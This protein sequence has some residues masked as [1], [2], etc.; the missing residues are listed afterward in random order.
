MNANEGKKVHGYFLEAY[1]S[2]TS[3]VFFLDYV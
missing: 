2:L 3:S 1:G